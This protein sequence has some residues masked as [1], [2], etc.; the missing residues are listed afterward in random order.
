MKRKK[1]YL[2]IKKSN[3]HIFGAFPRDKDGKIIA[4]KYMR[5]LY[6]GK[7]NPFVIK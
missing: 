5:S 4:K 7:K 2:I 6:T 1:W 3:K